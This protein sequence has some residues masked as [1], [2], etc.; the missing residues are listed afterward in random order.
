M[1]GKPVSIEIRFWRHVTKTGGCW[2]WSGSITGAGYGQIWESWPVRIR[3]D[4]HRFSWILHN[5]TIPNDQWV[6]HRCDNK[7]C[8]NP[9]HLYL[10]D[11]SRNVLD[12]Q[13]RGLKLI[14]PNCSFAKLSVDDVIE[15][16][17]KY[18][19]GNVSQD[20][21]ASEYGV[22]QATIWRTLRG[23]SHYSV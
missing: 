16:K 18:A 23:K 6:L 3:H 15:I 11:N 21:L 20:T 4:A 22:A 5:G 12:A 10:G 1:A 17:S 9:Q 2:E 8:V 7:R 13:E 14:G 19:M